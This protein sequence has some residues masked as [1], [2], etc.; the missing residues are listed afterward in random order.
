M[1]YRL[2]EAELEG[3]PEEISEFLDIEEDK[4]GFYSGGEV[5]FPSFVD[6][7]NESVIPLNGYKEMTAAELINYL[8]SNTKWE[9]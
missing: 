2:G 3:T 5:P 8:F 4:R 6:L 7:K 9:I 1:K